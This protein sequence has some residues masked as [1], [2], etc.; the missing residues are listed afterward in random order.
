MEQKRSIEGQ[1]P[2][3][4]HSKMTSFDPNKPNPDQPPVDPQEANGLKKGLKFD[5]MKQN[6]LEF[7]EGNSIYVDK[8][9][10]I[11]DML[12]NKQ[13]KVYNKVLVK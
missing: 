3:G 1:K 4:D 2:H 12:D 8:T 9:L 13:G 7:F 5:L 11:K 10:L 6:F